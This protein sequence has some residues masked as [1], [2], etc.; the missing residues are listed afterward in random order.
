VGKAKNYTI[1]TKLVDYPVI[2]WS[3]CFLCFNEWYRLVLCWQRWRLW[4]ALS[5]RDIV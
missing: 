2:C 5:Y 3:M 4:G 1:C